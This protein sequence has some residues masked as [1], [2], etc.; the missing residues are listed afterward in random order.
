MTEKQPVTIENSNICSPVIEWI[1]APGSLLLKNSSFF[2]VYNNHDYTLYFK[3]PSSDLK[4]IKQDNYTDLIIGNAIPRLHNDPG[5]FINIKGHFVLIRLSDSQ[6]II[7]NDHFGVQKFFYTDYKGFIAS[8]HPENIIELMGHTTYDNVSGMLYLL[9]NYFVWGRTIFKGIKYSGPSTIIYSDGS[10]IKKETYLRIDRTKKRNHSLNKTSVAVSEQLVEILEQYNLYDAGNVCITL[11]GGYDSRMILAGLLKHNSKISA[12]TFGNPIS[13]DAM[14]ARKIAES[15]NIRY[16]SYPIENDLIN[17]FRTITSNAV[18]CS[19]GMLNL[20]RMIRMRYFKE[21]VSPGEVLYLGYA[22]SEIIRGLYP[23][24]LL[25]SRF[26]ENYSLNPNN[27]ESIVKRY[28][29]RF[30][31]EYSVSDFTEL[32]QLLS[33]NTSALDPFQHLL[34]TIIPLHFGED[35]RWLEMEGVK[36]RAPFMDIDFVEF[37]AE[38]DSISLLRPDERKIKKSHFSRIDNPWLSAAIIL[39][40]NKKL[41]SLPLGKGFSPRDYIFSKYLA[42]IKLVLRKILYKKELVTILDPWYTSFLKEILT[43][44]NIYLSEFSKQKLLS[45]IFYTEPKS[46]FDFLP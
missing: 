11:T 25:S 9:F 24:G 26:F 20:L 37:L 34:Q 5:T 15:F 33:E 46:E 3:S 21:A 29:S 10:E 1:L 12:F 32:L 45:D 36:C 18:L 17:N 38:M 8:N 43:D 22:G 35:L 39:K 6:T 40:L 13:Q 14:N 23:D 28:L 19:G 16:R 27:A 30:R 31:L 7:A 41:G 42:G 4:I 2:P 44:E